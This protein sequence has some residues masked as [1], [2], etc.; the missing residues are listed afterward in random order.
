MA[1][2]T[3]P[4]A[5]RAVAKERGLVRPP[6]PETLAPTETKGSE[7][8][9]RIAQR[10]EQE[11]IA[12]EHL[13][14]LLSKVFPEVFRLPAV[15]LAIGIHNQILDVAGDSIDPRELSTF[16]R[17][18]VSRWSYLQAV[19]R[20][21]PR[22]NLDGSVAGSPT[23]EQRND[24]ARRLWGD[25]AQQIAAEPGFAVPGHTQRAAPLTSP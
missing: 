19:W 6:K 13:W 1:T 5:A 15:P 11:R 12:R 8:Q 20:G 9:I 21:E 2:L 17:Y 16:L 10:R 23:I 7:K 25:R 18:W 24:A 3:A 22:L 4:A 14:P